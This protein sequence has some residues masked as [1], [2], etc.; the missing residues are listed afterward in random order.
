MCLI[1]L[2]ASDSVRF[3]QRHGSY[4]AKPTQVQSGWPGQCF[5]KHIWSGSKPVCMNHQPRF[6]ARCNWPTTS[7]PLLDSVPFF[8]RLPDHIV[9]NQP[10]SDLVLADC[11][12]VLP[13]G[14]GLEASQCMRITWPASVQS[15][16][17]DPYRMQIRSSMFTGATL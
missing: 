13:C 14:S 6:L 1:Q 17:A 15:F 16:Q 9:Q 3:F 4:C 8:H 2:P 10:R 12:R 5:A 11:V 7:F